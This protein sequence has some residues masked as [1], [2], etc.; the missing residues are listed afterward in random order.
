MLTLAIFVLAVFGFIVRTDRQ[1]DG[2]TE[3]HT[4]RQ[5]VT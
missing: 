4:D 5:T 1:T 2:R 3:S